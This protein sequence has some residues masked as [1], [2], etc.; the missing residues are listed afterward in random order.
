[1]QKACDL[2]PSLVR[3]L[4]NVMEMLSTPD[5]EVV[6]S[7]SLRATLICSACGWQFHLSKGGH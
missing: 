6:T 4:A 2:K 7:P 1:M 5:Q 3:H